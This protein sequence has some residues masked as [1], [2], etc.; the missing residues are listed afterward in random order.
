MSGE[1]TQNR[2]PKLLVTL[3]LGLGQIVAF[4]SSYYLMGVLGDAI[5]RELERHGRSGVPLYLVYPAGG[6]EPRIL[7]QLLTDGLV[8]DSLQ[9]AAR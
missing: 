1:P 5:A 2:P 9:E 3:V 4:A 8:I 7:P 6:G